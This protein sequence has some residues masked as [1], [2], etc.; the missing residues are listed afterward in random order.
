MDVD[1]GGGGGGSAAAP[2]LPLPERLGPGLAHVV[3]RFAGVELPAL[4][5]W[6]LGAG[7]LVKFE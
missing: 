1:E 6:A 3:A 4:R 7:V 5:A 2:F